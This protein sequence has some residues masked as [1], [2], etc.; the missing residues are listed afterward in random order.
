[1]T[2]ASSI[3]FEKISLGKLSPIII[4]KNDNILER[5]GRKITEGGNSFIYEVEN[6][7]DRIFKIIP[8]KNFQNGDQIRITEIAAKL[9]ISPRYYSSSAFSIGSKHFVVIEMERAEK[10]LGKIMEDLAGKEE[11]QDMR[12]QPFQEDEVT[13]RIRKKIA[14]NS[15]FSAAIEIKKPKRV[16]L[17]KAINHITKN[18]PERFYLALF[19][20]I[21]Q[22]AE[23][24]IYYADVHVGNIIPN[25]IDLLQLID[26]DSCEFIE[27]PQIAKIRFM[28]NAY[29]QTLLNH[30]K[31]IDQLSLESQELIGWFKP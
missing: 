30:Y 3:T 14:Q 2:S 5:I 17:E 27:N 9:E 7:P 1:M 13:A 15:T 10:T 19:N 11:P 6:L 29:F 18:Q 16:S 22:L 28:S 20:R 25:T 26:F 21:K 12:T 8:E 4:E 23:A 24:H 31:K